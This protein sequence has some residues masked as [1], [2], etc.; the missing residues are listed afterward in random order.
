MIP[1]PN[2]IYQFLCFFP[3]IGRS[4][5]KSAGEITFGEYYVGVPPYRFVEAFFKCLL[6]ALP[7]AAFIYWPG[8][9]EKNV[10][11][12]QKV[13]AQIG[14]EAGENANS[15]SPIFKDYISRL[16]ERDLVSWLTKLIDYP[17]NELVLRMEVFAKSLAISDK[18][19]NTSTDQEILEAATWARVTNLFKRE[20]ARLE[21][22][23]SGILDDAVIEDIVVEFTNNQS[24]DVQ[25][26]AGA[27]QVLLE[28]HRLSFAANPKE[29]KLAQQAVKKEMEQ[30]VTSFPNDVRV[31]NATSRILRLVNRLSE[32]GFGSQ[33]TTFIYKTYLRLNSEDRGAVIKNQLADLLIGDSRFENVLE[34][35]FSERKD[36]A[37]SMIT[38]LEKEL[39]TGD[40]DDDLIKDAIEKGH[41]LLSIGD[42]DSALSIDRS[43]SKA[44]SQLKSDEF[45]DELTG[46]KKAVGVMQS[47]FSLEGIQ[48][49]H[50]IPVTSYKYK[51]NFR[52]LIFCD[53][54]SYRQT[55]QLYNQLMES[56]GTIKR[57][58]LVHTYVYCDNQKSEKAIESFKRLAETEGKNFEFW[59][60][61]D[62]T[63]SPA[64]KSRFAIDKF[65]TMHL[66]NENNEFL[67]I[68]TDVD[69]IE[70]LVFTNNLK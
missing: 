69:S 39:S 26:I 25:A 14:T 38:Q 66:V 51:G 45:E 31:A 23:A 35:S 59:V 63:E 22:D 11:D 32:P 53:A 61:R 55:N 13:S 47:K 30:L 21:N 24:K 43:V 2:L 70:N 5:T 64:W 9:P 54:T 10:D 57:R 15:D 44:A 8:G 12:D 6:L 52:L 17:D 19:L 16:N 18:L 56:I 37:A 3:F 34:A 20:L 62:N 28:V 46:F 29:L 65:P 4:F 33:L 58:I 67:A 36:R 27:T 7:V 41:E 49:T 60:L 50:G 48:D 42:L 68:D 40:I 1:V